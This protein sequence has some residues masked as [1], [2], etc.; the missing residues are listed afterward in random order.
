MCL[1]CWVSSECRLERMDSLG[2]QTAV[3]RSQT[4]TQGQKSQR[5]RYQVFDNC[6]QRGKAGTHEHQNLQHGIT[7]KTQQLGS[8]TKLYGNMTRSEN[9]SL[10]SI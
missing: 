3:Q 4:L 1:A 10:D 6:Q 5:Q 7:I 2:Q 8:I 9:N